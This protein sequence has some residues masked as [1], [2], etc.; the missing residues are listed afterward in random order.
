MPFYSYL[1]AA[2]ILYVAFLGFMMNCVLKIMSNTIL[3]I[4]ES[5]TEATFNLICSVFKMRVGAWP[6]YV[7]MTFSF[8]IPLKRHPDART[9]WKSWPSTYSY[10][11][12][13]MRQNLWGLENMGEI[14]REE[15]DGKDH[16]RLDFTKPKSFFRL[17]Q[18]MKDL[19]DQARDPQPRSAAPKG[20]V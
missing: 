2:V 12:K 3:I 20:A 6:F 8:L 19:M 18:R 15:I 11:E 9:M 4:V 13:C 7:V 17:S 5:R 16:W 14:I 1:I 10:Y